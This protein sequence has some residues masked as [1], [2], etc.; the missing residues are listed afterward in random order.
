MADEEASAASLQQEEG[1]I[2]HANQPAPDEANRPSPDAQ[3]TSTRRRSRGSFA[4]KILLAGP[5]L[6]LQG[7]VQSELSAVC[8]REAK[9]RGKVIQVPRHKPTV[10]SNYTV[11]WY[12]SGASGLDVNQ[13]STVFAPTPA[14]K[15]LLLAAI[16]AYD[17]SETS[18]RQRRRRMSPS[19]DTTHVSQRQQSSSSAASAAIVAARR[20]E[21]AGHAG[22]AAVSNVVREQLDIFQQQL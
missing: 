8:N 7:R 20:Q 1:V 3:N 2:P 6:W 17:E 9:L 14:N 13:L 21:T 12:S 22:A 18:P 19:S 5:E 10:I 16:A 11:Q 15:T 4:Q